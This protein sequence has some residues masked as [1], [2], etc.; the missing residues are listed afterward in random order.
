MARSKKSKPPSPGNNDF[1][2]VGVGAS[3]GG[4]EAFKRLIR[5]IPP[6]SGMAFILVQHL[7]PNHESM[8]PEI[9][10]KNTP[11]PVEEITDNVHV[12]PNHIYIIPSNK[13]LTADDGRLRLK[14]RPKNNN[15]SLPIDLFFTSLAEV[16][17]AHAIGVVLSGTASDGTQGLKAIRERGGLTFAQ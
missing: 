9:L 17:G 6:S 15:K 8:L 7:E 1:P 13:L 11:I 2:V 5:S 14:P 4:L 10:Q 3:A 12:D 16:H